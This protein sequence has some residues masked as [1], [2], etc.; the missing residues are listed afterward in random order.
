MGWSPDG[1][2]HVITRRDGCLVHPLTTL[3]RS[4]GNQGA[5]TNVRTVLDAQRRE[6][7]IIQGLARRLEATGPDSPA[8]EP[9]AASS[10]AA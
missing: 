10:P 4:W 6:D 3:V 9:A 8:A 1:G 2:G 5:L 7:W